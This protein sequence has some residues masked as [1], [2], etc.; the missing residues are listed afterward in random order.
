MNGPSLFCMPWSL[1]VLSGTSN[2]AKEQVKRAINIVDLVGD[3]VQLRREG[4]AYK[5]LCP[6]HTDSRPSLQVNAER[7]S[8][9][10]W[11][12]DIGGD[13]FSFVMKIEG[14]SFPEAL[15][16]LAEKAGVT[17][18]HSGRPGATDEKKLQLQAMAWAEEQYHQYLLKSPDAEGARAYLAKRGVSTESVLRFHLGYA[19]DQWEWIAQQA[20]GTRYNVQT[21]E[22]IDV[23]ARRPNGPGYYDRFKGRVLFPIRD[24]Q[25]RPVALGGRILPGSG[26]ERGAKYLNSRETAI[27]SKSSLLYGLDQAREAITKQRTAVVMEGYTDCLIAQQSGIAT[28]VAALGVAFGERHM[29]LLRRYA[30]RVV[31]VLDGDEAGRNRTNQLL[32]LFIAQ[33]V[34][35]RILTLP[36][37]LDP[38]DFLLSRGAEAFEQLLA[39]AT[40]AL[41]HKFRLAT[42][43][44]TAESGVHESNRALEEVLSTLARAARPHGDGAAAAQ[45]KEDQVLNR[46]AMKFGLAEE[47]IRA[48]LVSLR[49]S[50]SASRERGGRAPAARQSDA[51]QT[52]LQAP[53][54]IDSWE[55]ELL[56]LVLQSPD[57]LEKMR[58][59]F[60]PEQLS[61]P[62]AHAILSK[63]FEWTGENVA[64]FDRLLTEF[65]EPAMKSLLVDL[66]ERGRAKGTADI[67]ARL[68]EV[69]ASLERRRHEAEQRRQTTQLNEQ[70]LDELS[71]LE[72]LK[73]IIAGE[74]SRQGISVPTDGSEPCR[75]VDDVTDDATLASA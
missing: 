29:Q 8:W 75:L 11:P 31:L 5:A 22:A 61:S 64:L 41:E 38:C 53:I 37:Q 14:I 17:L 36:D 69:V 48:R 46:L 49:R 57:C 45:L 40:D 28:A 24:T 58:E 66:D 50:T 74:R 10:C 16:M 7:Q 2:D 27:F 4:R 63:C 73:K 62:Q 65:D 55:R 44:L 43:K 26:E 59:D 18:E 33:P 51:P 47:R 32:E 68:A 52:N 9:K 72:I 35:L 25:G 1:P 70:S 20:S 30:D 56:E 21:L 60:S 54:A 42:S 13:V 19:P 12:C 71:Q 34:D 3:Y 15:K 67:T 23:V 6:W 39:G